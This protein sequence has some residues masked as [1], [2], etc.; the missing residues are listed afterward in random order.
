MRTKGNCS[1][2][3]RHNISV[4]A[5]YMFPFKGNR[6]KEGW[7]LSGITSWH[8]GVHFSLGEGD[9]M[10]T[11][12]TFDNERPNYVGGCNVYANQ[13]PSNWFNEACFAPSQYGTVGNLGRNV[14]GRS[15][16]CGDRYFRNQEHEDQRTDDPPAQ[17]R[18]I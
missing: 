6:L 2:D 3:L 12:N 8:T 10:D 4:N 1:F 17:G 13:S 7:Q 5:V 16:L 14:A 11:G 15:R 9:Q 18:D